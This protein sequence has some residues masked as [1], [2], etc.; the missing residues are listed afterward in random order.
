MSELSTST[1]S[2][3]QYILALDA[4]GTMTDAILVKPDGSFT[5]GKSI[6][7]R[8]DEPLS[9]R[10]STSDAAAQ[11]GL[12]VEQAHE[13]CGA[14]IYCGTGMLNTILTGD[15]RKVG[16]LVTRGFEDISVMEGGLS[17]LGQSQAEALHQQLH[18]HTRELVEPK[19]VYGVSERI[20]GGCYQGNIH[21]PAGAELIPLNE[22]QVRKGVN[23]LLDSEVEVVG[24]LFLYSFVDPVHE[25]RAKAICEEVI[26]ARGFDV[27]VVCSA[28][29]APVSKENG[30]LK[31][32]L[33]QC[34]AAEQVRESLLTVETQA[35]D[36]GYQGRLLTLLSYGGAVNMEY[37]RLYETM[38]SGPIGGLIGA[39]FIAD[40]LDL[41][42][43]VTADMGG[44]SFDVGLVI[45]KRI[46]ITKSADLAGHR[47]A[48]PMVELDSVGSGAGSVVY[49]DEYKRLHVGPESAGA[50]VGICFKYDRLTVTDINVALG[51]V[52]PDYFLGGQMKLDRNKA[53]AALKEAVADPLGLDVYEA[54]AGVLDVVNTEMN[55]LLRTMIASKGYDTHDFTLLYY[56]GAGPVHMYGFAEGI[57]FADVITLPW[58]AG[59]SAFGAACAEYMHRYDRGSRLLIPNGMS[60]E[61]LSEAAAQ[62]RGAWED[63]E[64][65]AR[66]EMRQEGVD[67]ASLTFRYGVSARYIGQLESFDTA[68]PN[69]EM[70]GPEGIGRLIDAFEEMYTKLYPAGARFPDTGYSLTTVNL[71]AIAPKPRPSLPEIELSEKQPS[72]D[73]FVETRDVYHKNA[74][75]KF[76]VYEMAELK[77]GNEIPG[78]AIIRDPM[79]TVVIPP[80]R[81]M[82]IDS[83]RI[84]HY[85]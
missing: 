22:A 78:P 83:R 61:E 75:T 15:G 14:D 38:I 81:L 56:G 82:W 23:A 41:D 12:T 74:W 37:P 32:L 62:I 64:R 33:F 50:K 3:R 35:Q 28:D 85:R 20:G 27:P 25:H 46:G 36:Y 26:A 47:L 53:L 59:F 58:A 2:D 80:Q 29:V 72:T 51:Y 1:H 57:E 45:D 9:Y 8:E 13:M 73:A 16:L 69:G 84:L 39:Q 11:I 54:G 77:P 10:E 49:V 44:T 70:E 4:G 6:S 30:R 31:S 43:V 65:E 76:S 24:I 21:L 71:E 40:K 67:P 52:D 17:Y 60:D 34:F 5:V 42:N 19:N 55:D 66:E 68:L 7:R 18:K 48:L 63:L 79:T